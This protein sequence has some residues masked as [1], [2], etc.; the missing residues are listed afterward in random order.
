VVDLV[1]WSFA[2]ALTPMA[3]DLAWR[4]IVGIGDSS[5]RG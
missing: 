3:L 4:L 1:Q 5:D 2:I